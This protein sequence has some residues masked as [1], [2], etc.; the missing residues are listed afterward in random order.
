MVSRSNFLLSALALPVAGPI[1]VGAWN[2]AAPGRRR[3]LVLSGG[4]A[5][6]AYEAGVISGLH[7]A[8]YQFDLICGTSTGAI[9]AALAAQGDF[10]G[11]AS[12]WASVAERNLFVA[13]PQLAPLHDAAMRLVEKRGI[14]NR[15]LDFV[16]F[17][18]EI[19]R[20]YRHGNIQEMLG[21]CE[22]API[23]STLH[24]VLAID[25]VRTA[26]ACGVTNVDLAVAEAFCVDPAGILTF[27]ESEHYRVRRLAPASAR[28]RH[29][30]RRCGPRIERVSRR[31]RPD[32]RRQRRR[33][34]RELRVHRR[35]RCRQHA[36]LRSPIA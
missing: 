5:R 8:G 2:L 27:A 21:V 3:A 32:R 28:R 29:A 1:D 7:H 20:A 18:R 10:E 6:G 26:F 9:N 31:A 17:L 15:P 24:S 14:L 34:R 16:R 33:R 25:R 22:S 36:A 19:G 35:R 13:K 12:L 11:L 4:A 23:E 30:L